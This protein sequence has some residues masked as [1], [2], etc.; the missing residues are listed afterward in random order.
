VV[1]VNARPEQQSGQITSFALNA[2]DIGRVYRRHGFA[3]RV[4]QIFANTL[5]VDLS[6]YVG[7]GS[8]DLA[9]ID[10]CHDVRF[11]ENDFLEVAPFIRCGGMVLLH[12]T[13]AS[14]SEH[15][16]GSYVACVRLRRHGYDIRHV[17]NTWWGVWRK[18]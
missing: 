17:K 18:R 6:R 15:L 2:D 1:T 14:M 13:H 8:A 16:W 5:D 4:T 10:A 11:V 7:I 12:D 3:S 9:I